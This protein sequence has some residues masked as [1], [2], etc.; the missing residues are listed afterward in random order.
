MEVGSGG[1]QFDNSEAIPVLFGVPEVK[2]QLLIE[3]AFSACIK[4]DG[5]ADSHFRTDARA[6]VEYGGNGFAADAERACGLGD[7]QMQG[8]QAKRFEYFTG[9]G[10]VV[11]FHRS[12]SDS[13]RSSRCPR[14]WRSNGM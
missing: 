13:L 14:L 8:F 11:H 4:G 7:S 5:E 10:R 6:S 12:F 1:G 2:L 9:M 3:P